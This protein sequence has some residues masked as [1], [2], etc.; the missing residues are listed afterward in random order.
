MAF[1]SWRTLRHTSF[2]VQNMT[3][4]EFLTELDRRLEVLPREEAD[5]H[6][7]YYAEILA[8]RAECRRI[9]KEENVAVMCAY[10]MMH[11]IASGGDPLD[12]LGG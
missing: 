4:I 9:L 6:L 3:R 1:S 5:R 11:F 7:A 10:M 2:C 8:D 12:F